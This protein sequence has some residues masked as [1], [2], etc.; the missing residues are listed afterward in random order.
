MRHAF[1]VIAHNNFKVLQRIVSLLDSDGFDFFIHYDR[2][3]PSL[4][5]ITAEKSRIFTCPPR[6]DVRWGDVSLINCELTL[7][8]FSLNR[9]DR[10]DYYHIISGTHLP[11]VGPEAMDEYFKNRPSAVFQLMDTSEYEIDMKIRRWN[12]CTRT[13]KNPSKFIERTSQLI[14][15][16]SNAIQRTV[17]IKRYYGDKFIKASNWCSLSY[18]AACHISRMKKLLLHKYKW[19]FCG[20]EFF[21]ASEIYSSSLKSEMACRQDYLYLQFAG[22][23]PITLTSSDIKNGERY[24]WA[25]KFEDTSL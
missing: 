10:Y 1:L 23:S 2:K 25:R 13:F 15:R 6:I 16:V 3:V 12:I 18:Q 7:L 24:I 11:L 21:I 22:A 5:T 8:E 19:A 14:W 17:G 9:G 20:D 4:P